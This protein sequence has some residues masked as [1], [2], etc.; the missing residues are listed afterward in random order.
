MAPAAK[1]STY[2]FASPTSIDDVSAAYR[3]A[4]LIVCRA[5]ATTIAEAH[6]ERYAPPQL[7]RDMA[8]KQAKFHA[9]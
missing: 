3:R 2:S 7:L 1:P 8:E 4:D 5:G 6:G 9:N